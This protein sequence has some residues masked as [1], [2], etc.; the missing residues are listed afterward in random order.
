MSGNP[1]LR[2]DPELRAL[3]PPLDADE[4]AQL[5]AN[6]IADGCRDPIVIW[7]DVIVDGHNRYEL[8]TK[9]GISFRTERMEFESKSHARVW[10]R[11]NQAGRRN[12]TPAWKI[13]LALGNKEDLLAIGREKQSETLG[14][15]K[16]DSSVLSQN[17]KTENR[18]NT[19]E[20][21]AKTAGVS[22]GSVGMA[23][24]IRK[25][26]PELW[27]KAKT[28]DI[29]ISAA[30]K[31][32]KRQDNKKAQQQREAERAKAAKEQTQL[33]FDL[34]RGDF[35]EALNDLQDHS[36]DLI[37]TDPPY[38]NDA[39]E[40]YARLA[41]FASKKLQIGGH[42]I[43]YAGQA[44]IAEVINAMTPDLRYWWCIAL[45]HNSG[46]QQMPGKWVQIRWK[47]IL[48]FVNGKRDDR[49]YVDDLIQGS[50]PRKDLHAWAQGTEEVKPLIDR[51]TEPG[52]L[53]VDPFAGSGTFGHAA[54]DLGRHFIGADNGSHEDAA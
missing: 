16:H 45:I 36:V 53:I 40:L 20:E 21:V 25:K 54:N 19:R 17:D 46:L 12:L 41:T 7:N 13:E 44:T 30:Y 6:L 43:T 24:Q 39:I 32:V 34:R 31:Q 1:T 52:D 42:L 29:A 11:A 38:G 2:V 33:T 14:G 8:C 22:T 47:P 27:D 28:G 26:A 23:E 5:E 3:I 50:P 9:N 4:R 49:L 37:L 15:Y 10:M 18:H 35:E 48:W 51:L